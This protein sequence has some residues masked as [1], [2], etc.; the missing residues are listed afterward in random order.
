MGDSRGS[1]EVRDEVLVPGVEL[2][3]SMRSVGYSFEAAI[4]DIVDNSITAG[5]TTVDIVV[6]PLD[7]AYVWI[8]DDGSG[9]D[10]AEARDAL[11]LAGSR[12]QDRASSDLGRFGL[13]LKTA[14]LSQART[15]SVVTRKGGLTTGLQWDLDHV[16]RSGTWAINVLDV[17]DV[18]PL[19][20]FDE[21]SSHAAGTLV[22]W[23]S[24]D[25][26][27]AGAA[28]PAALVAERLESLREHLGFT[29]QRFLGARANRLT[30]TVNGK[31]VEPLDPFLE[32][33]P[34]TQVSPEER[35][36]IGSDQVIVQAYTL[37]HPSAFTAA[38]RRRPDLGTKMRELQG[39]YVYRNDRLISRGG[40]FGLHKIDELTKQSRVRVEVPNSLDHL[41]QLDIKKSRVEPPQAFRTRFRQIIDQVTG[42]SRRVHRFRGR[43]EASAERVFLWQRVTERDG[44]RY[45]INRDHPM[46]AALSSELSPEKAALLD[47]VMT[48]I[49]SA[50]PA[51][52]LY[53][54][55]A[56]NGRQT[57]VDL[58]AEAVVTRLRAI[59]DSGGAGASPSDMALALRRVEPF[60]S[61]TDL[62]ELIAEVW[63]ESGS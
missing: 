63:G 45:T 50:L 43:T 30:L 21:F 48:D 62:E 25:Y 55:M 53:V 47:Q 37:P 58:D 8:L 34:R 57:V 35:I 22:V 3:E 23:Q 17:S 27:L 24:P 46:I 60:D 33:K 61:F 2:L 20:G 15:L 39:F 14:S 52:D 9:M 59:R 6:D 26:L 11:R 42:T 44:Y 7:A 10:A 36:S 28:D 1:S 12:T 13:G 40:W 5:A 31:P 49:A 32:G 19:P 16:A 4:A 38:D 51:A 56:E 29:F 54:Q 18:A 41:W